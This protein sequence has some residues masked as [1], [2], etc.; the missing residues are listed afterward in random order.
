MSNKKSGGCLC[1][2]IRYEVSSPTDKIVQCHCRNC[3]KISGAGASANILVDT[4]K[5]KYTSGE[6]KVF[7]DT[8]DSGVQLNR[9]FC[10]NCGSSLFSQRHNMMNKLVLK[11]GSLDDSSD[12]KVVMNIWRQSARP[13]VL[14]DPEVST[15]DQNRPT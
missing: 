13:W 15:F 14:T 1:G 3:Q 2:A 4:D 6:P 11:A 5:F 8:G 9:A 10:G 7:V 12:A